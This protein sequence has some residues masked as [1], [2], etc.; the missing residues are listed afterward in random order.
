MIA[1][2]T[3]MRIFRD[4]RA[5]QTIGNSFAG[6]VT[7]VGT[8]PWM[9]DGANDGVQA[10]ALAQDPSDRWALGGRSGGGTEPEDGAI[11]S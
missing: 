6:C 3:S 7:S 11:R 4:A 2:G 9:T 8:S 5:A 1:T 10:I